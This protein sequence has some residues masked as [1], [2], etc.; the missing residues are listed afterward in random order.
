MRIKVY[1]Q[2]QTCLWNPFENGIYTFNRS[3]FLYFNYMASV[4]A[5]G[6]E[7]SGGH[8]KPC[9]TVDFCWFVQFWEHQKCAYD[10][11]CKLNPF[12]NGAY[13]LVEVYF[14]IQLLAECYC[15]WTRKSPRAYVAK[16][17]GRLLLIRTVLRASKFQS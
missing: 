11:Y 3:L 6:P 17:Y 8:M 16:F 7:I 15:W 10:P 1:I 5:G 2:R 13:I 14:Y 4:T 9:S 12:G